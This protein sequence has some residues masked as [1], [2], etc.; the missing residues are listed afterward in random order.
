MNGVAGVLS[1][2]STSAA[3][4]NIRSQ[5]GRNVESEFASNDDQHCRQKITESNIG[6]RAK[7]ELPMK[8]PG[9]DPTSRDARV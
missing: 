6:T 5:P 3:S 1:L 4:R 8:M 9:N 7:M 2:Q